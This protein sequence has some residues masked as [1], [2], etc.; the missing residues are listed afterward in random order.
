[1]N[2]RWIDQA[3]YQWYVEMAWHSGW[4]ST[5]LWYTSRYGSAVTHVQG[6]FTFCVMLT[7]V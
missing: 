6:L 7:E 1:V 4:L 5:F 3:F 2:D